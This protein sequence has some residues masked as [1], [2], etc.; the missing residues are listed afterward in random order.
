MANLVL[1][2]ISGV[3]LLALAQYVF[4]ASDPTIME[5]AK[6]EGQLVFYSSSDRENIEPLIQ[7]FNKRYPQ[8]RVE[9]T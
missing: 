6:K 4:A 7:G 3:M 2:L 9:V 1:K 5:G 8:I